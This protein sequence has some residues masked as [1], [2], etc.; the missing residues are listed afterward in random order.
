MTP[1]VRR[2]LPLGL[3][4][5]VL[6]GALIIGTTTSSP[7][8]T[9]A[10]R[11][12]HITARLR[13]PVCSGETVAD[14]AAPISADIRT[15]VAERVVAGQSDGQITAYIVHQYPGTLLTPPTSGVGLIVWLLPV[16]AFVAA[17]GLLAL[18]FARWRARPALAVTAADRALVEAE[19]RR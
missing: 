1:A 9:V 13:C 12:H 2:W 14:S 8:P 10:D 4:G 15:A 11:V 18:A 7:A 6:V 3:L 19:L 16:L 5:V 17:A